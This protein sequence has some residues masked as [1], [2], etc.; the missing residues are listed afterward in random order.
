MT[1][2]AKTLLGALLP[3]AAALL[4][5]ACGR[6]P[7]PGPNVLWIVWDTVRAD[8]LSLYDAPRPTTP[9]LESWTPDAR[10]FEDCTSTANATVASHSSMFTGYFPSEHGANAGE[11]HLADEFTTVAEI[12]RDAGYR[13]YL[14]SSN[15]FVSATTNLH[16]GF[17]VQEHPWDEKYVEEA[18]RIVSE[19]LHDLDRSTELQRKI[20]RGGFDY[21]TTKASG[22]IIRGAL[23]DWL[24][25]AD[26]ADP[27]RPWFA[28]LNY[29]EAHRPLIPP[30][31]YRRRFLD[32]EAIL[33]AY[34]LDRSWPKIWSY[35]FGLIDYTDD[36]LELMR[37]TYDAGLAELDELLEDLVG[38]LDERGD[39]E[40]TII[41]LVSDHGEQLGEHHMLDH[42]YSV[43]DGL[44]RVPLVI[45]AP[46]RLDPGRDARPV[47]TLD[48]LPTLLELT[49][50]VPDVPL[51]EWGL[52]LAGTI[53]DDRT[54]IAE[55]P[56]DFAPG[57][58]TIAR[59]DPGWDTTPWQRSLL[60][61]FQDRWKLIRGSDGGMELYDRRND[62]EELAD[63]A[64]SS[65]D[66]VQGLGQTLDDIVAAMAEFHYEAPEQI[67]SDEERER[68]ESLGYLR[69]ADGGAAG[70]P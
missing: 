67:L 29:M 59:L 32:E 42:Q 46:G 53:P 51:P 43:Y 33:R 6:D 65:L 38:T 19:K 15:P 22:A 26:P 20:Q 55:Y 64:D 56:A 11:R 3:G 36:E 31:K 18:S 44:I 70:E 14:Y 13:T 23:T 68:L 39:I 21:R 40:N 47:S 60:A 2:L 1:R 62:A 8:R 52:S 61:I 34:E 24:D 17:D 49:G 50:V 9:F 16:Q 27:D 63:L 57:L 66:V 5:S 10:V 35:T 7:E 54:R 12:F 28:Y 58:E 48:I 45:H 25:S 69:S 30:E 4:L 41:V 37:A